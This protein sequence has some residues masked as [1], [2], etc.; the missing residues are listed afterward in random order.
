MTTTDDSL[1]KTGA[2][3]MESIR[4]MVAAL[5]CD[6]GR[7]DELRDERDGYDEHDDQCGQSGIWTQDNPDE[8][9]ELA[10]LE[11]AAGECK[12]RDDAEQRIHE[13]PLSL[14][15]RSDWVGSKADMEPA[16]YCLLLSTGGPATRIIGEVRNGEAHRARLEV[17]D[18]GTPWTEH[19]TTGDDHEALLTYARCFCMES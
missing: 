2:C 15:L 3:A 7:L 14:E 9:A 13:D 11:A 17:Q 12:D 16:E 1:A 18:W 8:A 10:A 4:E 19:I 6:Y 5:E